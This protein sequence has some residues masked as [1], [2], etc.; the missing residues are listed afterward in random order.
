MHEW[1][2][3]QNSDKKLRLEM[4]ILESSYTDPLA[5]SARLNGAAQAKSEEAERKGGSR[6]DLPG[7]DAD[8]R[9]RSSCQG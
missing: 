6:K 9:R 2:L 5:E 7:E 3:G 1:T 8:R 4:T